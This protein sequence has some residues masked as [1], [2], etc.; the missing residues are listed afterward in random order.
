MVYQ[1]NSNSY[2]EYLIWGKIGIKGGDGDGEGESQGVSE[3]AK[4][5][6]ICKEGQGQGLIREGTGKQGGKL[7]G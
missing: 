7:A 5:K 4:G 3:A 2:L 1:F 6:A